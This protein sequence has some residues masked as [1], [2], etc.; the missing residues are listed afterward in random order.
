MFQMSAL[1]VPANTFPFN[2]N[3]NVD[4]SIQPKQVELFYYVIHMNKGTN[5]GIRTV[6]RR[7]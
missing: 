5:K 6:E 3:E 1:L 2:L 7:S 4:L